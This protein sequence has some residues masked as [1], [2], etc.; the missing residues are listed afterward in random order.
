MKVKMRPTERRATLAR[1]ARVGQARLVSKATTHGIRVEVQSSYLPDQ[2]SPQTAQ[3][4][5]SYT[6][7][8]ANEGK[9]IVQLRTRHWIITDAQ[10]HVEEVKGA[11]VVGVQP[12]I[13][14][15][16]AFRY[17]SGCVLRT[18]SGSMHG[19]YQMFLEDGST[20]DAAIPQFL[21]V[22]PPPAAPK[23]LN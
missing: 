9:D 23:W 13:P 12:V 14:P 8:I 3:W 15:G 10:G 6:V 11:G 17:T 5:F 2:S 20:F 19:S 21:L 7:T 16:K 4:A 22:A 1:R 18:Q